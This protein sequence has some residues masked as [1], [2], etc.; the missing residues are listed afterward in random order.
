MQG[1]ALRRS[2]GLPPQPAA[3]PFCCLGTRSAARYNRLGLLLGTAAGLGHG[4]I[5]AMLAAP[6]RPAA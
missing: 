5:V 2:P 3:T 4:P 6:D 1:R